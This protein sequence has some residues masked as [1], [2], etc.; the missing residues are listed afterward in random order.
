MRGERTKNPGNLLCRVSTREID[1]VAGFPADGADYLREA[2]V[3]PWTAS[4]ALAWTLAVVD[5]TWALAIWAMASLAFRVRPN[6]SWP[7]LTARS[8]FS[9]ATCAPFGSAAFRPSKSRTWAPPPQKAN[10]PLAFPSNMAS[11]RPNPFPVLT[12]AR[13]FHLEG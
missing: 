5:S 11:W 10:A 4:S 1:R 13:L 3:A 6:T 9:R 2:L 12:R 7:V 8:T